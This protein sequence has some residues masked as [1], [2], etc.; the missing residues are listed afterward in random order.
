MGRN[1]DRQNRINDIIHS[2]KT[3][4]NSQEKS[5]QR[6]ISDLKKRLAEYEHLVEIINQSS[7]GEE[8]FRLR[9]EV[10]NKTNDIKS[11]NQEISSKHSQIVQKDNE[12][13]QLRRQLET[14]QSEKDSLSRDKQHLQNE[15]LQLY[16][17]NTNLKNEIKNLKNKSAP[18][19]IDNKKTAPIKTKPE[20]TVTKISKP[21]TTTEF[22]PVL[23]P[24]PKPIREKR[25]A[26]IEAALKSVS[27]ERAKNNQPYFIH[28]PK[29][30]GTALRKSLE[31]LGYEIPPKGNFG[32]HFIINKN[33]PHRTFDSFGRPDDWEKWLEE[34]NKFFFT[35]VRNPF[36]LLVSH[37]HH[38]NNGEGWGKSLMDL[39]GDKTFENY[40]KAYCE[41][42]HSVKALQHNLFIQLFDSA[43][44][45]VPTY[46]VRYEKMNEG[47]RAMLQEAGLPLNKYRNTEQLNV[48]SRRTVRDWK[49]YYTP[50]LQKMVETKC[51]FELEF[52]GYNFDGPTDDNAL[53]FPMKSTNQIIPGITSEE[54][55]NE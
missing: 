30:G 36:D 49:K 5:L 25:P 55:S 20:P 15:I 6:E 37:Y 16:D 18:K 53:I 34:N 9:K 48:S 41:G 7:L 3:N 39:E 19:A 1:V 28:V 54:Y 17:T 10:E 12:I 40:I 14:M 21:K 32:G 13:V 33:I 46:T 4:L 23:K 11:R 31:I 45:Y 43:G 24:E 38:G 8:F 27:K 50:E 29:C 52:F 51:K 42:K 26:A 2:A 22:K 47:T 35:M 44:K